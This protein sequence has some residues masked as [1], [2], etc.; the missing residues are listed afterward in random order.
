M[1]LT[2]TSAHALWSLVESLP[3]PPH[4]YCQEMVTEGYKLPCPIYFYWCD[5]LEVIEYT[6]GNPIFV[7]HMQ[8]DPQ[9]L[10]T[11]QLKT[12]HIYSEYMT[13]DFAWQSQVH[14]QILTLSRAHPQKRTTFQMVQPS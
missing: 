7:L 14:C 8:F 2:F 3:D 1:S 13:G 9:R 12:E 6:F 10:W 5:A 4:W 11:D